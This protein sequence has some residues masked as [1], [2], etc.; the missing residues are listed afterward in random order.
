MRVTNDIRLGSPL[1]LAVTTVNFVATLKVEPSTNRSSLAPLWDQ[2]LAVELYDHSID[3][4]ET[5]NVAGVGKYASDIEVLSSI[6]HAQRRSP[7]IK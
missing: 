6:L 3:P 7:E 4:Q 5:T 1:P 2:Q